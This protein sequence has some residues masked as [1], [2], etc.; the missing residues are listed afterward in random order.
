MVKAPDLPISR[1]A[2]LNKHIYMDVVGWS[3][4]IFKCSKVVVEGFALFYL[5]EQIKGKKM[6]GFHM[7]I[8]SNWWCDILI[9]VC[10]F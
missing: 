4:E 2:G 6:I 9:D 7:N 8:N 3:G 1:T 10:S 5:S